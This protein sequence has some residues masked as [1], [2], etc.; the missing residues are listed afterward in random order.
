MLGLGVSLGPKILAIVWKGCRGLLVLGLHWEV[1]VWRLGSRQLQRDGL[2]QPGGAVCS[3]GIVSSPKQT[4]PILREVLG[5]SH[6]S[7]S[8]MFFNVACEPMEIHVVYCCT[9]HDFL[10]HILGNTAKRGISG[11]LP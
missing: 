7:L 2:E 5:K 9:G 6:Q 11:G 8:F 3:L 10:R 4:G 1:C